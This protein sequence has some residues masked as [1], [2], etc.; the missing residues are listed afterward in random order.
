MALSPAPHSIHIHNR[1]RL[2]SGK[3][4][5]VDRSLSDFHTVL[6]TVDSDIKTEIIHTV[7][8]RHENRKAVGGREMDIG[9]ASDKS[10][11]WYI[12]QM[13]TKKTPLPWQSLQDASVAAHKVLAL[14]KQHTQKHRR[15]HVKNQILQ[16]SQADLSWNNLLHSTPEAYQ[17]LPFPHFYICQN[18]VF[19]SA[20]LSFFCLSFPCLSFPWLSFLCQTFLCLSFTYLSFTCQSFTCLSLPCLGFSCLT[21][22]CQSFTYMPF[23]ACP[24]P[25]YPS[26][27]CL[28]SPFHRHLHNLLSVLITAAERNCFRL[29]IIYPC[30]TKLNV[31][32][33]LSVL[34]TT[35]ICNTHQ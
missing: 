26:N 21:L 23:P 34:L 13:D 7:N 32:H 6:S 1:R 8:I 15:L 22:P 11:T 27:A 31:S 19:L 4:A 25:A 30:T 10:K 33:W 12:S 2:S 35:S 16:C 3:M 28:S 18:F 5:D 29:L 17:A 9:I 24:S 14:P 20:C